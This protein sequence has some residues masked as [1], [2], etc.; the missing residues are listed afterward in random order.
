MGNPIEAEIRPD[1]S[2]GK[3]EAWYALYDAHAESVW[4]LVARLIGPA[5]ADVADVV[6]ETFLAAARSAHQFDASRGSLRAWLCGIARRQVAIYFRREKRQERLLSDAGRPALE[7]EHIVRW[8]EGRQENPPDLLARAETI[9][10]VR[11]ALAAL[12]EP[13]AAVLVERYLVGADVEQMAHDE[14]C[15]TTAIRSRLA[16][17][18]TAF[19]RAFLALTPCAADVDA[20]DQYND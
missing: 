4:R 12:A 10:A 2:A 3:P 6:Q 15:G 18:R 11:S 7:R 1:L 5:R 8:L 13:H 14:G 16:R 20:R 17:A 9:D 19:C